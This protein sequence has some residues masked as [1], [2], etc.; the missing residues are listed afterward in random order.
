M[1]L[2]RVMTKNRHGSDGIF[3]DATA[4]LSDAI[5]LARA[6][7]LREPNVDVTVEQE[8]WPGLRWW[9]YYLHR[10]SGTHEGFG[11]NFKA[12]HGL[13]IRD[14]QVVW[15]QPDVHP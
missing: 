13:E 5:R 9:K 14:I 11:V 10:L 15:P 12:R 7:A 4:S 6:V 2:Y 3:Y 8:N 1:T